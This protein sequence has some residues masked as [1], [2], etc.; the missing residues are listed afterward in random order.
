MATLYKNYKKADAT[1]IKPGYGKDAWILPLSWI[2]TFA[3]AVGTA[4]VG[5]SVTIDDTH[6]LVTN[7]GAIKCYVVPKTI[8]GDGELTGDPLAK[9]YAWKPKIIF[10]GDN[11]Q[12]YEM[13]KNLA[14]EDFLLFVKDAECG[15]AQYIQYGC[16]C[17][18]CQVDTGSF[19]SGVPG[20]GRKQHELTMLA[21]CKF[22]YNGVLT[23]LDDDVEEAV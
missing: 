3:E 13:V 1:H 21:Y 19:K 16:D 15:S 11:P 23:E 14:N 2:D 8:E 22:F 9:N 20:T 7:K 5:N 12:V 10:P 4:A 6:L 18:P 17:D